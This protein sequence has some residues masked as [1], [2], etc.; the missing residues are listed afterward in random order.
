MSVYTH[1]HICAY[2]YVPK[3]FMYGHVLDIW[4]YVFI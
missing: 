4:V 1:T 3:T 2:K